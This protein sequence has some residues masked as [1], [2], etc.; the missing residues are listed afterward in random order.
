MFGLS[1]AVTST[2][3]VGLVHFA[4]FPNNAETIR[5]PVRVLGLDNKVVRFAGGIPRVGDIGFNVA[6]RPIRG[7][8][9]YVAM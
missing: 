4:N 2:A 3:T 5:V 8:A 7:K 6:I 9:L 1:W